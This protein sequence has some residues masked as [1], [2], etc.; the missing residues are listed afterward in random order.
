MICAGSYICFHDALTFNGTGYRGED[1]IDGFSYWPDFFARVFLGY[2]LYDLV[3]MLV[4]RQA[5]AH[6]AARRT[7][8]DRLSSAQCGTVCL[9]ASISQRSISSHSKG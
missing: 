3:I 8:A 2:L 6:P 1:F 9:I 5:S 4:F 7:N